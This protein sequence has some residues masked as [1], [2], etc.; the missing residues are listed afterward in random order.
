[1]RA[2]EQSVAVVTGASSGI[3][4]ASARLLAGEGWRVVLVARRAE[5][6]REL[7]AEIEAA[8]G[9][10]VV[11]AL[12]AADGEAVAAMAQRVL[13]EIGIPE[14]IVNSA[15][16]GVWKF[17]EETSPDEIVQMLGAPF[18]AAANTSRAFMAAMLEARRG[19]LLHVGSPASLMPWPG[20]TAYTSSR[21]ALRGLH[22]ALCMDLVGT[23]VKSSLV[24]FGEVSSEYFEANPDSHQYIPTI[25]RFVP[26]STPEACAEV[27]L[28]VARRPRRI[29]YYPFRLRLMWWMARLS[30]APT[31]R[32]IT[33]TG[34]RH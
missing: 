21:W 13:A 33:R 5:R 9:R 24:Y 27:I 32:L 23:G 20:A 12:D 7:A 31:R 26:L 15:G 25:G 19:L 16:A 10:A 22:E 2:A 30:P 28:D 6:L 8:G 29:V 18:L 11:E 14:L 3:G 34:R 4:A 1:M 17:L